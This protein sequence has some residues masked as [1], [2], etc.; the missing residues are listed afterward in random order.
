MPDTDLVRT[1]PRAQVLRLELVAFDQTHAATVA[2]W[3]STPTESRHWCGEFP[4]TAEMVNSWSTPE[5]IQAYLLMNNK[6]PI[7]YGELWLDEDETELARLIVAPPHRNQ[8]A[9]KHLVTALTNIALTRTAKLIA[10]RVHPDN[11]RATRL[12]ERA[13]FQLVDE[14]TAT[15]WNAQQPVAYQWLTFAR[16]E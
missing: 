12:Y 16:P 2:D 3:P 14:P 6:E 4:L 8:G 13:G 15:E 11:T 10:L 7:G 9:G 1:D 5:D